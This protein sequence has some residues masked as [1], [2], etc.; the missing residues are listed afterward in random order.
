MI[1]DRFECLGDFCILPDFPG[2]TAWLDTV[3]LKSLPAGRHE[4]PGTGCYAMMFD[5]TTKSPGTA[6]WESHKKY[7][8]IQYVLSGTEWM[9]WCPLSEARQG[10]YTEEK[11]FLALECTSR[12]EFPVSEGF[13]AVFFPGDAHMPGW[14]PR[15]GESVRK[16][17]IKVPADSI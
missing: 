17:V 16:L 13:A 14:S 1:L 3:D 4:I 9:S 15:G 6:K 2:V 5:L 12:L 7:I 8:D 10:L 11:D